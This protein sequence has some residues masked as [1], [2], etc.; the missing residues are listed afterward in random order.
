MKKFL[1]LL[2]VISLVVVIAGG[3][4]YI[5]YSYFSMNHSSGMSK[6]SSNTSSGMDPNM[7][8]SNTASQQQIQQN[9]SVQQNNSSVTNYSAII[10][11][12]KESLGKSIIK[13]KDAM[14]SY[15][16]DSTDISQNNSNQTIMP[17]MGT[18]YDANK[19]EQLH[20]LLYKYAVGMTILD[21]LYND[22]ERQ[23]QYA[24]IVVQNPVQY[25]TYQS[26]LSVQN[27]SK[28]SDALTYI[29]E[30]SNL[31][32]I[33]PYISADGTLYD[34]VRMT[35]IHNSVFNLA[36]GVALI[37]ILS[38]NLVKQNTYLTNYVQE[39]S[40]V[41][42]NQVITSSSSVNSNSV[43]TT[44]HG[45]M[46]SDPAGSTSKNAPFS[47]IMYIVLIIFIGGLILGAVGYVLSLSKNSNT[48]VKEVVAK[49]NEV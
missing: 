7:T 12:N 32:T 35:K 1:S 23:E 49:E 11:K 36:E 29:N 2:L 21:E 46:V 28:L 26:T 10:L 37:N 3:I 25:F 20:S 38:D 9:N 43:D 27:K 45:A 47:N 6:T 14:K 39:L 33:N 18:K 31:I 17:D 44:S 13:I 42:T 8:S 30:A 41:N 22:L 34:N 40:A 19:M 15:S 4:G 5:G 16:F 24:N 48:K